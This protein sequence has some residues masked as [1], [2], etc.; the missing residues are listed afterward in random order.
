[1]RDFLKALGLLA[2]TVGCAFAVGLLLLYFVTQFRW[3]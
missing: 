3:I 1:V 2:A